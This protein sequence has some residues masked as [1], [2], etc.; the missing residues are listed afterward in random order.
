MCDA[1]EMV[2]YE[3]FVLELRTGR[4]RLVGTIRRAGAQKGVSFSG[5]IA[6]MH[7]LDLLSASASAELG[8][9]QPENPA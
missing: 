8:G 4:E 6:L 3:T 1:T 9:T 2:E 5:W 7:E